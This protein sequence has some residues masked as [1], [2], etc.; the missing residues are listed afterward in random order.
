M[1]MMMKIVKCSIPG[2]ACV[3]S[4]IVTAP[5]ADQQEREGGE[6]SRQTEGEES[7]NANL[8]PG[9]LVNNINYEKAKYPQNPLILLGRCGGLWEKVM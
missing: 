5:T 1:T 4:T 7:S 9:F 3:M 2:P 6:V 8:C